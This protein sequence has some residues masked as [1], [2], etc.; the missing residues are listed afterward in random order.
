MAKTETASVQRILCVLVDVV[1]MKKHLFVLCQ[2][3][4]I[5]AFVK[6]ASIILLRLIEHTMLRRNEQ[7]Q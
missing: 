7:H 6:K 5:D 2:P 4:A 1:L 3:V